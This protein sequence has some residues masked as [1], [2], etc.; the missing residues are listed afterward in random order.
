MV[1]EKMAEQNLA[2]PGTAKRG[3]SP[4]KQEKV[5]MAEQN[6]TG[7][8]EK[9]AYSSERHW[10]GQKMGELSTIGR[11]RPTAASFVGTPRVGEGAV[12]PVACIPMQSWAP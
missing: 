8:E 10:R 6:F 3:V 12:A 2:R 9:Q 11:N 1:K 7:Q 4:P 5:K